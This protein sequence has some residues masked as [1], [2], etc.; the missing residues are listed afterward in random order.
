LSIGR[1]VPEIQAH[2]SDSYPA[3]PPRPA[4]LGT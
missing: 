4:L 2:H 3:R 1:L